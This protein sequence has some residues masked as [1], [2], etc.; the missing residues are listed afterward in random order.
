MRYTASLFPASEKHKQHA[1]SVPVRLLIWSRLDWYTARLSGPSHAVST[2]DELAVKS[3][4]FVPP[5]LGGFGP[6]L[7]GAGLLE[8]VLNGAGQFG[9][10]EKL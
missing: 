3:A 5:A 10:L 1:V 7:A 6:A 9:A 4:C 2:A 8:G